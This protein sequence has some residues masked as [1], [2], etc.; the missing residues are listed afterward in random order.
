[1]E[2]WPDPR[3]PRAIKGK[4]EIVPCECEDGFKYTEVKENHG[5]S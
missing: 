2:G 4:G 5:G 3:N 1:M